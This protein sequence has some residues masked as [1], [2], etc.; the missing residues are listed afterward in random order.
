MAPIARRGE[1]ERTDIG[2]S[3]LRTSALWT[4]AQKDGQSDRNKTVGQYLKSLEYLG[5]S[6]EAKDRK[7]KQ[8]ACGQ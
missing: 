5:R 1:G 4:A 3:T 6:S 8:V 2:N 7:L